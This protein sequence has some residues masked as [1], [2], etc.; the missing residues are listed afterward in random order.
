MLDEI[1]YEMDDKHSIF[2][3]DRFPFAILIYFMYQ[4]STKNGKEY[5]RWVHQQEVIK[6]ESGK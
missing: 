5:R 2:I 4:N 6:R 1:P 3:G